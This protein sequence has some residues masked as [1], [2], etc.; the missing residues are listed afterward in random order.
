M[1]EKAKAQYNFNS[2][3]QVFEQEEDV[4]ATLDFSEEIIN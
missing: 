2:L 4:L 3:L 1:L